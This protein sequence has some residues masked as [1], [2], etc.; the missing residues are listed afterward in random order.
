MLFRSKKIMG[1]KIAKRDSPPAQPLTLE[2]L[3]EEFK[4]I[5]P[6]IDFA[7][8]TAKIRGWMIAN[9]G[10]RKLT[11]RFVNTWLGRVE[12]PASFE[13]LKKEKTPAPEIG[14]RYKEYLNGTWKP[15]DP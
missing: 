13:T 12:R 2:S 7:A 15:G 1:R 6:W 14:H 8:E 3:I 5:Y 4:P 11:R 9:P 10:K